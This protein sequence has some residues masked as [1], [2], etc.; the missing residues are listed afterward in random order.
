MQEKSRRVEIMEEILSVTNKMLLNRNDAD[1]CI[2]G[3]E[4]RQALMDEFDA[5]TKEKGAVPAEELAEIR[6]IAGTVLGKNA[7]VDDALH[8]LREDARDGM[9]ETSKEQRALEEERKQ[10]ALASGSYLNSTM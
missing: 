3:M 10:N 7:A 8:Q 2:A 6:R 1:I 5:L 9:A 4:E